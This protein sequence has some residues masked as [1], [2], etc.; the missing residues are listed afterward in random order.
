LFPL[1]VTIPRKK[2]TFREIHLALWKIKI[3]MNNFSFGA[4]S[5]SNGEDEK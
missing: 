1:Q 3:N 5:M 4:N 2:N